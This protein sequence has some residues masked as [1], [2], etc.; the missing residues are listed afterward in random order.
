MSA[1]YIRAPGKKERSRH[2]LHLAV[3]EKQAK[4]SWEILKEIFS[5]NIVY[6]SHPVRCCKKEIRRKKASVKFSRKG[7]VS[8]SHSEHIALGSRSPGPV[9]CGP[10]FRIKFLSRRLHV[11]YI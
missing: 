8:S 5:S 1:N 2:P 6:D 4:E 11:L 10:S 3:Y 9:E 7:S